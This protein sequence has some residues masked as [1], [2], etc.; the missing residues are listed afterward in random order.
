[1]HLPNAFLPLSDESA[2]AHESIC[3]G[4]SASG[5]R[6][7]NPRKITVFH[8]SWLGLNESDSITTEWTVAETSQV[9]TQYSLRY[10]LFVVTSSA[11]GLSLAANVQ[12]IAPARLIGVGICCFWCAIGI[13]A[14]SLKVPSP[15][16][17]LL[18]L[19]GLPLFIGCLWCILSGVFGVVAWC[20]LRT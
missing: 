19:G 20:V 16:R 15:G 18:F 2:T 9:E 4:E 12:F 1:I 14:A 11:I 8:P 17:E 3:R 6:R 10:L 5:F 13:F 7:F